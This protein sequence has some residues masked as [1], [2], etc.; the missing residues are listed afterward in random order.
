MFNGIIPDI[1]IDVR[2]A[3]LNQLIPSTS[4]TWFDQ[5][6]TICDLKTL[7]PHDTSG[8]VSIADTDYIKPIDKRARKV[9]DE[10]TKAAQALDEKY[11][12]DTPTGS[13][14]PIGTSIMRH[15][16]SATH[17]RAYEVAGFG[18]GTFGGLSA[19]CTELYN[20]VARVQAAS[21]VAYCGD[22]TP[23]EAFDA[24][25]PRIHWLWGLTTQVGG[26]QLNTE[27]CTKIHLLGRLREPGHGL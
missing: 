9:H 15:G 3:I 27:R 13:K 19:E 8:Y 5:I 7:S 20:L 24:Q 26:A 23:K 10:Y 21:Y 1:I 4:P 6:E 18:V 11:Y 14:G 16:P 25:R 12:P 17:P 22:K 2:N